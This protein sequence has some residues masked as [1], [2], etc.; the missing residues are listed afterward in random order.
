MQNGQLRLAE[1]IRIMHTIGVILSVMPVNRIMEYL[2][3][4]VGSS[5]EDLQALVNSQNVCNLCIKLK[6]VL[7]FLISNSRAIRQQHR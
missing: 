7:T 3:V 5:V 6:I 2:N 1:H 4:I